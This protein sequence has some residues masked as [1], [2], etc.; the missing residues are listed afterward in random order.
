MRLHAVRGRTRP[1]TLRDERIVITLSTIPERLPGIIPVLRSLLDQSCPADRI[2]LA[3]PETS[4]RSGLPYPAPKG[5]PKG[6]DILRCED[7]GPATKLL[8]TLK[9]EP[10]SVVIVVDDDVIYPFN[11]VETLLA[12]HRRRPA[13]VVGLRGWQVQAGKDSRETRHA[14]SC[15]IARD[16]RVDVLLGSWGYLLP[17]HVLDQ[18]VHEIDLAP[19]RAQWVDDVWIAGHLAKRSIE[20]W[21]VKGDSLPIET[22]LSLKAS[23]NRG[24]NNCGQNERM[25]IEMFD[26]WWTGQGLRPAATEPKA[27]SE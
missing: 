8:P 10:D 26:N 17:P 4:R 2:V 9:A 20:R 5:L 24:V 12:A 25:A 21:V 22:P 1:I 23:L 19:E 11:F 14:F 6:I 16:Q 27:S 13:A 15:A 3:L 7:I 18:D